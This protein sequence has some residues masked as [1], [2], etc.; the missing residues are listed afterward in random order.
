MERRWTYRALAGTGGA[1]ARGAAA[2]G[3]VGTYQA[4]LISIRLVAALR[5]A[6]AICKVVDDEPEKTRTVGRIQSTYPFWM[7]WLILV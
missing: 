6:K 4:I 1:L 2:A 7:L 3:V 5:L